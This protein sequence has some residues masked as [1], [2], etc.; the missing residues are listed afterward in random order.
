MAGGQPLVVTGFNLGNFTA[1][2]VATSIQLATAS[3]ILFNVNASQSGT[4]IW[5]QS[6]QPVDTLNPATN[7]NVTGSWTSGQANYVGIDLTRVALP[8]T[9]DLVQ[10]INPN[11]N[12][13]TPDDVPLGLVM[14]Y[15][16][17]ISTTP[18]SATPNLVPVAIVTLNSSGQVAS[19]G[20]QDARNLM[21]RLGTGG[22]SPN[23]G[24]AYPWP[25]GRSETAGQFTGGDKALG[26]LRDFIQ[27][28]ETRLW[29]L[30]GGE[31]WY[32]P[33]ADRNVFM[34]TSGAGLTSSSW[35]NWDGTYLTWTGITFTFDNSDEGGVYYNTVANNTT[36]TV[37]G[38]MNDGDCIYVDLVRSSNASLVAQRTP[39]QLL[40]TPTV[41]GSRQVIAVRVGSYVFT[42]GSSTAVGVPIPVATTSILG[43]VKLFQTPGAPSAPVVLNLDSNNTLAWTATGGTIGLLVNG[44]ATSATY[45]IK[46]VGGNNASG[47]SY[48]IW[49]VGGNSSVATTGGGYGILGS[50]GNGTTIGSGGYGGYFLGG[51]GG[52]TGPGGTAV[53][54]AGHAGGSS[55]GVG[56]DG[57]YFAGGKAVGASASGNGIR[58]YGGD[59]VTGGQGGSG[60]IAIGGGAGTSTVAGQGGY[61]VGG[62]ASATA[63]TGGDGIHTFGANYGS[64]TTGGW[65]LVGQGGTGNVAANLGIGVFGFTSDVALTSWQG[66]F[67]GMGVMGVAYQASS[68]QSYGYGGYFANYKGDL[69]TVGGIAAALAADVNGQD[70]Y[71]FDC[72]GY[73]NF[74]NGADPGTSHFRGLTRRNIAL[75]WGF[76]HVA[77]GGAVLL[78]GYNISSV[79]NTIPG[80]IGVT[81]VTGVPSGHAV[82]PVVSG[83]VINGSAIILPYVSSTSGGNSFVISGAA[84]GSTSTMTPSTSYNGYITFVVFGYV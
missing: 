39:I 23:S 63:D 53:Y 60:V 58:G 66:T 12:L 2:T 70:Q 26:S 43:I 34:S 13:E 24:Y 52:T 25:Q 21:W 49:G 83:G 59:G 15:T 72:G 4:F 17:S 14:Q 75:A 18:F 28:T 77:S 42:R 61:F 8:S 16:I 20:I 47:G 9:A 3:S 6:N 36:N 31:N 55:S 48:G 35:F 50:G 81:L 27:A 68:W 76:I 82:T 69:T 7:A 64:G 67:G 32:S 19:N 22:D 65:G 54:G 33:T 37:L 56:G 80:D 5:L 51:A 84:G 11:T 74:S 62:L 38:Q 45:A 78:D 10:F 71:A 30:G 57:G 1:G 29:E 44:Y 46:G 73:I 41:P 79:G 40:G